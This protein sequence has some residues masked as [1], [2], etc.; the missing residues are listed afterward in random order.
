MNRST[1]PQISDELLSAYIDGLVTNEERAQV[2]A[3]IATDSA[4]AWELDT[5]R[6][7]VEL[8]RTLPPVSLPRSFALV[9]EHV[10]DVLVERRER[11]ARSVT[12]R[13]S[14][15]FQPPIAARPGNFWTDLLAFFN[16]GNL[17]LRNAAAVAALFLVIVLVTDPASIQAP[18]RSA[19]SEAPAAVVFQAEPAPAFSASAEDAPATSAQILPTES[20]PVAAAATEMEAPQSQPLEAVQEEAV[21]TAMMA[22]PASAGDALRSAPGSLTAPEM[23]A[24]SVGMEGGIET[25]PMTMQ[26]APEGIPF[27]GAAAVPMVA[28]GDSGP[29]SAPG[30]PAESAANP[31]AR[32]MPAAEESVAMTEDGAAKRAVEESSA[33]ED[34]VAENA[35]LGSPEEE[36]VAAEVAEAPALRAAP[37]EALPQKPAESGW[38]T[39]RLVQAALGGLAVLFALLWLGSRRSA[40][41]PQ[42]TDR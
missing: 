38:S 36:A 29:Q 1:Q 13:P 32:A 20:A 9:E 42:Q 26:A 17:L 15:A 14:P 33:E 28:A 23:S 16:S 30:I 40:T 22:A 24:P 5:L 39:W 25:G 8:M 18:Q 6:R 2:E 12:A 10:A 41:P 11:R 37:V 3:A 31:S 34:S 19:L 7:T 35:V 27:D 21:P 4:L